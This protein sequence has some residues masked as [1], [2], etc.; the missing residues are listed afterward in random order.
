MYSHDESGSGDILEHG[1]S[2]PDSPGRG[3]QAYRWLGFLGPG[4]GSGAGRGWRLSRGAVVLAALTLIAGLGAGYAAGRGAGGAATPGLVRASA[5]SAR[6]ARTVPPADNPLADVGPA[7]ENIQACSSQ[8]GTELQLGIEVTDTSAAPVTLTA[9]TPAFAPGDT[10]LREVGWQWAPC[11]AITDGYYQSTAPLT[12]GSSAWLAVTFKVTV[13][14]PSAYRVSFDV[15]YVTGR[16]HG[17]VTLPGFPDLSQV[18]YTGCGSQDLASSGFGATIV[19]VEVVVP[20]KSP[21]ALS[22]PHRAVR[23]QHGGPAP[24]RVTSPGRRGCSCRH[25]CPGSPG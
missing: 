11:G 9:V 14:C 23:R 5:P 8:S 1:G 24:G 2:S 13:R 18:A 20:A 4:D 17:T 22:Q 7:V 19:P 15:S 16:A 6:T 21:L 3:F 12:P 10:G 25:A